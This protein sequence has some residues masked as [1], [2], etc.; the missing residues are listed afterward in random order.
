MKNKSQAFAELRENPHKFGAPTFEEFKRNRDKYL[1]RSDD[2]L[3]SI[4]KGTELLSQYVKRHIYE[5]AGHR[6]KT[7][8]EVE[9]IAS[10]YNIPLNNFTAECL[11]LGGGKCDFLVKFISPDERKSREDW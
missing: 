7:L 10:D 1:G 5:I 4:D 11:P 2:T 3:S 9:R 6:C 8:E